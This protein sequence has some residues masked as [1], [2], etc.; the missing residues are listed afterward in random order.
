MAL[1]FTWLRLSS[2]RVL[3]WYKNS[4]YQTKH[5][6]HVSK[7]VAQSMANVAWSAGDP[8]S[9]MYARMALG[10]LPRGGGNGDD[11][12]MGI[13]NIMRDHNIKEGNRPGLDEPFLEQWHQK[14]H[15]NT[16]PDDIVICEA[17]LAFLQSNDLKDYYRVLLE[18]GK[19]TQEDLDHFGKPLTAQPMH[20]PDLIGSI[21]SF[22]WVLKVTHSGADLDTA[23]T[24]ASSAL[25]EE[26]RWT[27]SDILK[28][29]NEWWVPAK[30]VGAR[31]KLA[32]YWKA[33][34]ADRDLLLFDI[35]L[36]NWFRTLM[37]KTDLTK[38]DGDAKAEAT[39]LILRNALVAV[40]SEDLRQCLNTWDSL[41]SQ[42]RWGP[43]WSM[44]ALA[45][46]QR[47][48]LSLAAFMDTMY[49]QIQPYAEL[50]G[51]E[52][53]LDEKFIRNFGEEVV[54]GHPAFVLSTVVQ[55]LEPTVREAAGVSSWQ[56]VSQAPAVGTIKLIADL[57]EIQGEEF[58]APTILIAEKVGGMED[59]PANIT[60]VLTRSLTDV[61]SHVAIRA[62]SQKCLLASC[63]DE[64]EWRELIAMEGKHA[65]LQVAA[66]GRLMA[67]EAKAGA[68]C[69]SDDGSPSQTVSLEPVKPQMDG[70]WALSESEFA[71]Q[72]V[73][74]KSLNL[75][76]LRGKLPDFINVPA[77]VALP[78]GTFE[79]TL[80]H[81]PELA[82][83]L[84]N[85][86]SSLDN[87]NGSSDAF[88]SL[89]KA[90]ALVST[91]LDAPPELETEVAAKA[92]AGGLDALT[93]L[94]A[95][96][97][98]RAAAGG[99]DA[100]PELVADVAARATAGGPLGP[101]RGLRHAAKAAAGG[102]IASSD[103]WAPGSREWTGAWSAIC[104]VWASKWT[105]RAWLSRRTHSLKDDELYMA[106]LMQ[107][108]IPA[109]YAFVLHTANP[110]TRDNSELMGEL[111]VGMG[112][113]LVGNHP[114][115]ALS[116]S[117]TDG[118]VKVLGYPSKRIA[119]KAPA[120]GTLI[121]RS[122]ANGEDL[123]NFAGAGLYDSI[124][125]SPL[126]EEAVNYATDPLMTDK[127]FRSNLLS[128]LVQVGNSIKDA[129][130][131]QHQDIEGVYADGKIYVV[132]ARPQVMH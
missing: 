99:L 84:N 28:N 49:N 10:G 53:D 120:G 61:L 52:C 22:L 34:G 131:G 100:L 7:E 36:D 33:P 15:T 124:P 101:R 47:T 51:K 11:I 71:E 43:E 62:R 81:N 72:K 126:A 54:R 93:E 27:C 78:Y 67:T 90:S 88:V 110:V 107:Q 82:A 77:S 94:V 14:L 105:D 85:I 63:M 48:E 117:A 25:D 19:L 111:V 23:F 92:T 46:V 74:R 130:D 76:L 55:A 75:S 1:I 65:M 91:G 113:T 64:N 123:D 20:L 68:S 102:L 109:E 95:D 116:F 127:A 69:S 12:R 32:E 40:D 80:L 86:L 26:L 106:V 4:N 87:G 56:I 122:D 18:K 83:E 128:Q 29:R 57:S 2:T 5:I 129:F 132:Q 42:E 112:E 30:I 31:T 17:Y 108:V 119:L 9:R 103:V 79:R 3:P 115:R 41:N 59:I 66:D 24:M 38:M 73:G 44:Q 125:F 21:K 16:T 114:G 37:E 45:A 98:A 39:A 13:L 50:F 58:G 104:S 8:Y 97:A 121:A 35:A 70:P 60:A 6:A 96:V 89:S 118:S